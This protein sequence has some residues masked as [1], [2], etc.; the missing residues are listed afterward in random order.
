MQFAL[1]REAGDHTSRPGG[2]PIHQGLHPG[3]VGCR[4]GAGLLGRTLEE[5]RGN[6]SES[7]PVSSQRPPAKPEAWDSVSGS[8]P[9]RPSGIMIPTISAIEAP[10]LS[11][12]LAP[13]HHFLSKLPPESFSV[14]MF[15]LGS[16]SHGKTIPMRSPQLFSPCQSRKCQTWGVLRQS[17]RITCWIYD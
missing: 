7:P 1:V 2:S 17:R 10:T 4:A 16:F 11:H 3:N 12:F 6:R 9:P 5:V 15:L 13:R 14:I 8:K